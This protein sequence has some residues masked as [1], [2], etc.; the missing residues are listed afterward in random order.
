MYSIVPLLFLLMGTVLGYLYSRRITQKYFLEPGVLPCVVFGAA[1]GNYTFMHA[2][3]PML[4]GLDFA[5]YGFCSG[6]AILHVPAC[7]EQQRA[8]K[9][10]AFALKKAWVRRMMQ[11][12]LIGFALAPGILYPNHSL[13]LYGLFGYLLLG[14]ML[15][16][17]LYPKQC[18]RYVCYLILA[19]CYRLKIYQ[20]DHL[21]REQGVLLLGNHVSYIDWAILQILCPRMIRFVIHRSFYEKWYFKWFLDLFNV[22]PI[23]SGAS[24]EAFKEIHHTLKEG[25]VIALFPEGRLSKNGQL[26]LFQAG[27]ERAVAG[28]QGVIIPFYLHGLWGIPLSQANPHYRRLIKFYRKQVSVI[29]GAPLAIDTKASIVQQKVR[30]L[31][32]QSWHLASATSTA[33][34][35]AWLYQV[36]QQKNKAAVIDAL[37]EC[38]AYQL[39]ANVW[40]L[41]RRIASEIRD[42][43]E[44][45][46]LLPAQQNALSSILAL[47]CLNKTIIAVAHHHDSALLKERILN[48][49]LPVL[50]TSRQWLKR[51]GLTQSDIADITSAMQI[52]FVEDILQGQTRALTWYKLWVRI[53]P[54]IFLQ[55]LL[56]KSIESDHLS[57]LCLL[58]TSG[59]SVTWSQDVLLRNV[60]QTASILS[61]HHQD[62]ILNI[63]GFSHSFPMTFTSLLPLIQGIPMVCHVDEEDVLTIARFIFKY[64]VTIVCASPALLNKMMQHPKIHSLMLSSVRLVIAFG[65]KLTKTFVE[66]FKNKFHLMVYEGFGTNHVLPIISCNLPDVICDIDWHVHRANKLG[67]VGLPLPGCAFRVVN[68]ITGQELP[69]GELGKVLIGSIQTHHDTTWCATQIQGWLDEEGYLTIQEEA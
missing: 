69:A 25:G 40:I 26:N 5:L 33:I 24:K 45:G 64:K 49:R 62:R 1:L 35:A 56:K 65:D 61:L 57:Q 17:W 21:P 23:T 68:P 31:S 41:C 12:L 28:A 9:S 15:L 51:K 42:I 30:E 7:L 39:L 44:I 47:L 50:I 53:L 37:G 58:D 48:T 27:Y 67:T 4:V 54:T 6:I 19:R 43:Q 32:I 13:I 3:S 66:Q 38:S 22:I 52:L 8:F 16:F 36:K 10:L 14:T 46:L 34:P 59:Q 18:L 60:Y 2:L 29:Y 20:L 55:R 63:Y 11:V